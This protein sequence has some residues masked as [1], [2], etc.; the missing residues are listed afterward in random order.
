MTEKV[1]AASAIELP[2]GEGAILV[3][4][5]AIPVIWTS[6]IVPM[7]YCDICLRS[8]SL[9]LGA[10][11]LVGMGVSALREFVIGRTAH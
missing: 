9:A 3:A 7:V 8:L 10:A 1:R 6:L 11:A 4:F 5:V 2:E